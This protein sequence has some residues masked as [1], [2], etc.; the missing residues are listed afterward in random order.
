MVSRPSRAAGCGC[1]L[2]RDS[3]RCTGPPGPGPPAAPPPA[4]PGPPGRAVGGPAPAPGPRGGAWRRRWWGRRHCTETRFWS[5]SSD[6]ENRRP[7]RGELRAG[8]ARRRGGRR[9]AQPSYFVRMMHQEPVVVWSCVIG[10]VGAP[11]GAAPAPRPPAPGGPGLGQGV[12]LGAGAAGV[13][14]AR[15]DRPG[16]PTMEWKPPPWPPAGGNAPPP[17]P[18]PCTALRLRLTRAVPRRVPAAG[19]GAARQGPAGLRVGEREAQDAAPQRRVRRR[20]DQA[21]RQVEEAGGCQRGGWEAGE[22]P[23]T[24]GRLERKDARMDW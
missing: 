7:R 17:S 3:P 9:M 22:R 16:H 6:R 14:R 12:G 23:G 20:G 19:G 5:S 10:A 21:G 11:P 4:A 13:N 8:A 1:V 2:R 24:G 18:G 15:P